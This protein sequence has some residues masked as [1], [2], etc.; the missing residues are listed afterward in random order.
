MSIGFHT[1]LQEWSESRRRLE[2]EAA[3]PVRYAH[4]LRAVEVVTAELRKRVGQTFT[5]DELADAYAD[6]DRWSRDAVETAA[7][8]AGWP[9]WL[10][11]VQGAAFHLYARG[12]IDYTP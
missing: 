1:A 4:L 5:L 11:V 9:R 10:T 6:A 12:A 2:A 8:F 7:A 3:D